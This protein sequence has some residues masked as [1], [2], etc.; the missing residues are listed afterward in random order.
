MREKQIDKIYIKSYNTIEINLP[1][2]KY[3][4]GLMKE[5]AKF[6]SIMNVT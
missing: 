4:K 1:K 2:A 3:Y 5:G 6:M